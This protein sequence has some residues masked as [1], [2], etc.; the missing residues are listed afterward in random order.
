ML[1]VASD[2]EDAGSDATG[3]DECG[4]TPDTEGQ[5]EREE[6]SDADSV[7]SVA[8]DDED[9]G[10]EATGADECG[11]TPDTERL[12]SLDEND[13]TFDSIDMRMLFQSVDALPH[14]STASPLLLCSAAGSA[15]GDASISELETPQLKESK[16]IVESSPAA[17][18]SST[19]TPPAGKTASRR[20]ARLL[21]RTGSAAMRPAAGRPAAP[22]NVRSAVQGADA[23]A[24]KPADAPGLRRSGRI[25]A[26]QGRERAGKDGPPLL[27]APSATT[28]RSPPS[29]RTTRRTEAP[30]DR[31]GA[32]TRT[33]ARASP[34]SA[35][36]CGQR[37]SAR[38]RAAQE[39]AAR[40]LA[41]KPRWRI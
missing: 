15:C 18:S 38:I 28:T 32:R 31:A 27:S 20:S 11:A 21:A 2:D 25:R 9:A 35:N 29:R 41:E 16:D 1:S 22:T 4:A 39:G 40:G 23:R 33:A 5:L 6:N 12:F 26:Q 7:L 37:R 24:S 13:V 14:S 8:S 10:S 17:S 19:P 34:P 30:S 3:A 36:A